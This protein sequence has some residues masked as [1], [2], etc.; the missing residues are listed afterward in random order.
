[1]SQAKV[2]IDGQ[3]AGRI[4]AG[5]VVLLAVHVEDGP[6]ILE[7]FADKILKLRIFGDEEGKMNKSLLDTG[8]AMLV[9]SQFTLYGN[10]KKGNRPSFI[11]SA[12]PETAIPIYERFVAYIKERGVRVKTGEFGAD[13]EV[14]LVNIGPVTVIIDS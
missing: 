13:M 11:E 6:E 1:M 4:G 5:L 14:V 9:V 3:A 12:R 7:K 8:G 2:T 10:T